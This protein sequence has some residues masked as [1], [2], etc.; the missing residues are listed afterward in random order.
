[1]DTKVTEDKRV[2]A[3]TKAQVDAVGAV[4]DARTSGGS[5]AIGEAAEDRATRERVGRQMRGEHQDVPVATEPVEP[6]VKVL[7]EHKDSL[8][9]EVTA[10]DL[11]AAK[12]RQV[13][14]ESAG[15]VVPAE[16]VSK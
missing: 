7:N 8:E 3:D 4:I 12:A 1:M 6:S 5:D 14:E 15:N 11:E 13:V 2:A 16:K 9:T 10:G